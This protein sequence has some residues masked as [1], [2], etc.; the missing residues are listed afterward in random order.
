MV[1]ASF[2]IFFKTLEVLLTSFSGPP[3][4]HRERSAAIWHLLAQKV[5]HQLVISIAENRTAEAGAA[6]RQSGSYEKGY[7]YI[8]LFVAG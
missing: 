4:R 3:A 5:S 1:I 2:H 7:F 8:M 6:P